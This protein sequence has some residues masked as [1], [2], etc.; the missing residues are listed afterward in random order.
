MEV[1]I[2]NPDLMVLG[3]LMFVG[4]A[5]TSTRD[6]LVTKIEDFGSRKT[7]RSMAQSQGPEVTAL[8]VSN[9]DTHYC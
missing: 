4:I 6:G 1:L 8:A 5:Q 2:D 3:L 7:T 9:I